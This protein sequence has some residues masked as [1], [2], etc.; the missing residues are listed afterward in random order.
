MA[1]EQ[2]WATWRSNY[3]SGISD[4]RASGTGPDASDAPDGR[5]LFER[6]L[7]SGAPDEETQIVRRGE[8]CF[9]ILNRFPYTVGHLMVL[10]YRAVP[11]LDLLTADEQDEL[12]S[13]VRDAVVA[14]RNG[15]GC[16][17]VNVG[18]NLGEAAGGSQADHLHVHCVPRWVGDA[19]FMTVAAGTRVMSMSLDEARG[20][21]LAGW[22]AEGGGP[23]A[24]TVPD[25]G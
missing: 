10:P 17:A 15:L 25:D 21:V 20:R 24:D 23:G 16:A 7:D 6:I 3:I 13:T 5:S 14:L 11:D 9:V 8:T 19:N 2:L 4:T 12:W 22:P 18:L 1:F